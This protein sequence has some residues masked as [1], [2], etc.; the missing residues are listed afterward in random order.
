ME[1]VVVK[2]LGEYLKFVEELPI[3]FSLS[4]G[5]EDNFD[6]LPSALRKDSRGNSI[7]SKTS[8]K[9]FIEDFKIN[10]LIYIDNIN[11]VVNEEEWLVYAQHFGLPTCLL[12]FT[13]SHLISLMFAIE[14]AFSYDNEDEKNSIVWFLNPQ[15]L[16]M[17]AIGRST[18]V[19]ISEDSSIKLNDAEYPIVVTSKKNN[20]RIAAQ[21]GL[22]VYFPNDAI[23]LNKN[24]ELEG[25]L[26]KVLIPH[27]NTKGILKSLYLLGMRFDKLYPELS[28]ISKDILM[29]NDIKEYILM[30]GEKDE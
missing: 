30:E 13:Y 22:F 14:K 19:N 20:V 23:A 18:L 16:N 17:L 24:I 27:K 26:K 7:Y 28:S 12:D 3:E 15:K 5:Q 29:K 6:L 21:N 11:N 2:N 25:V 8:R 4:R 1:D 9:N 10:S